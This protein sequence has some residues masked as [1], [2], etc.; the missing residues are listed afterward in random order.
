MLDK[1]P[2]VFNAPATLANGPHKVE[3]TAYDPHQTPGK[4]T[5]DVIV[6]PPCKGSD[7]CSNATDVCVGGRCVPGSGVNGGLGTSCGMAT[8]CLSGQ[9]ASDGTNSYCV[10]QCNVGDC[11][12]DF[13][14]LDVGNGTSVCWPGYDDGSGG[15]CGCQSNR[16]GPLGMLLALALMVVTCRRRRR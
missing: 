9:C 2:F 12:S 1:G 4:A 7:D 3:I 11:P 14:C 15:G 6:G 16:G 13:G 10:E 8:D 5:V